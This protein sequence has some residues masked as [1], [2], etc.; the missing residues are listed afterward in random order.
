MPG[1]VSAVKRLFLFLLVFVVGLPASLRSQPQKAAFVTLSPDQSVL[2]Q[3]SCILQDRTGFLWIGTADGLYRYD[4]YG[5]ISYKNDLADTS[6]INCNTVLTLFEDESGVL[7][8]GITMGLERFDR[9]SV[10]FKHY[11]PNPSAYAVVDVCNRVYHICEGKDG[12]L[13]I[14]T[15][16]GLRRFDRVREEYTYLGLDSTDLGSVPIEAMY[17]D[18]EGSLWIGTATGLTKYDFE[19]GKFRRYW[20][21]PGTR[22]TSMP[23]SPEVHFVNTSECFVNTICGDDAGILWLGTNGGLVE[24]NTRKGTSKVYR[25]QS[26]DPLNLQH[27][28]NLLTSVCQDVVSGI[29]WIGSPKGLLSFDTRSKKFSSLLDEGIL[30]VYRER[31][32]TL[33]VGTDTELKKLNRTKPP[34]KTYPMG[35]VALNLVKGNEGK[36][37]VYAFNERGWLQFDPRIGQFVPYSSGT[38]LLCFVCPEGDLAFRTIDGSFYIRDTLGNRTFSLGPSW[39][40]FNHSLSCVQKTD[41]GYYAGTATGGLYLLDPTTQRVTEVANLR[42]EIMYMFEDSFGLLWVAPGWGGLFCYDHA[43]GTLSEHVTDKKHQSPGRNNSNTVYQMREDNK[44]RLWFASWAGLFRYE[45]STEDFSDI[46]ERCGL[47]SSS[48]RG[49]QEDNHG[50]LWLNTSKGMA[51]YD[52][53]TG[54]FRFYDVSYGL[55]LPSDKVNSSGCKTGDGEIFFAG[56]NGLTRF[57]PDSI[58]DNLY[59]PP[60]VVTSFRKFDKPCP[61]SNEVRLAHDDNF[62]S[63]EFAALSYLNGERNQYAYKMEGV[64]EDWVYSG[65][66]RYASY[67]NL[68]PG[69]YVFKVKGSNNEGLWNETGTSVAIV[70]SPPWWQTMWAYAMY[71]SLFVGALLGAY[72]L[73]I[74]Q[75]RLQQTAKMEHFQRERLAEVDRLKSR[76]FANI[77]HEFR[78]PLTL[79]LGP[80]EQGIEANGD[81]STPEKFK[82]IRDNAKKLLTLVGQLLDFSRIES[83]MMKLQVSKSDIVQFVRRTVMSFESWAERKKISLEFHPGANTAVGFFDGDKL[84][85]ILNNLMSNAV[86]FTGE[87]GSVTVTLT[88]SLPLSPNGRG[89]WGLRVSDTG[90]GISPKHLPHIFE[91]FYR[92]DETHTTEGTG[93]GLA[94]TKELVDLHHGTIAVESTPGKGSVF[95]VTLSTDRSAYKPEETAASPP[96]VEIRERVGFGVSAVASSPVPPIPPTDGK[97]I[98]LV[99]E[100]NADL[101]TYIREFLQSDYE[102]QEGGNG[103]EGYDRALEIVPDIV[104]SDVMMPEMDGME[105]CRALKKDVRTSHVPVILLTARAGTDSKI[106]GLDIGADDY[107]TKPFDSKELLARVRNLIEQRRQLRAK[108]SAGVVLKPGEVVVSS[109]DDALLKRVMTA[110]EERMSD[111]TLGAAE[112]ARE[113]ALSRR[114]LDRKLMGLTNLSTA[115]LIKYLRLQRARELLEKNAATVAEIAFQVGFGDPSYFSSCFHERFGILP[116]EVHQIAL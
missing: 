29:L 41:R 26:G 76:F 65:T 36:I 39:K 70:I 85:K 113:V 62:I 31:S 95:T 72:R 38:D 20:S 110:I 82:L 33:W 102:V 50:S 59:V 30:S 101:R 4:G 71:A 2:A 83:G 10:T 63:F 44:G 96:E 115:E 106:E 5:F 73:R 66:R 104:I 99:V 56:A 27:P 112:I 61:L 67:P 6:S 54:R 12:A 1:P 109:L 88:P 49:I 107:V 81:P 24:C 93:I 78:T 103:K 74:R 77:S 105:L 94:L 92:A 35:G 34:F 46:T 52:P 42:K 64:D 68:N 53:E 75:I 48:M 13:W 91:R 3:A 69:D 87:G 17:E 16:A 114:H 79:I 86:K 90:P 60:V 22:H 37:W 11:P 21:E 19:T 55:D 97:P 28:E 47:P 89:A 57:H 116:S 80:A 18:K 108:F 15:A 111:E 14:G 7:W 98:V 45:R 23:T 84:E 100:D 9:A 58:E 8:V 25:Y 43:K 51:K 32:G 40:A